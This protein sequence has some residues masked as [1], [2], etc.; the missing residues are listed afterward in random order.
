MV[1]PLFAEFPLLL[2]LFEPLF[3]PPAD[4]VDVVWPCAAALK[5]GTNA[6]ESIRQATTKRVNTDKRFTYPPIDIANR[7]EE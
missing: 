3:E 7:N 4:G 1:V 2:L 6:A 5:L